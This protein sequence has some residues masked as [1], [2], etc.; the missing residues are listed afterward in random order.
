MNR[1]LISEAFADRSKLALARQDVLEVIEALD[2]GEVRTAEKTGG[3]WKVNSWVKEAILLYFGIA[4]M[5]TW[6]APPFE[7]RDKM[8]LKSGFEQAGVRSVPPGTIRRGAYM[9]PGSI[10]M[11]GYVNIG[12]YIGANTMVDTWTAVGSCAQIGADVHLSA[13]VIVGGVLEPAGATPVIIEDKCFV[14]ANSV[15]VEGTLVEE[16]AVIAAGTVIT[17]ST[18]IIDVSGPEPKEYRKFVPANSIV[19]PGTRPRQFPSGTYNI[20]CALIIGKRTA[21]TD[22]KTSLNQA[23]R[24]FGEQK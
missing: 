19:I 10:L 17:G 18:H 4:G 14:G 24:N 16:G 6:E 9:A 7:Y 22:S 23:L 1:Q 5:Q 11:G 12:A 2:K 21:G 15:I 3:A 13:G 8:L 20:P